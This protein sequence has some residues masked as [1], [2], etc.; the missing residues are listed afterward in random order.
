M[1]GIKEK[2]FPFEKEP[3]NMQSKPSLIRTQEK[4][5]N[6]KTKILDRLE[7]GKYL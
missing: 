6:Y 1:L 2:S 3:V 5:M 4:I 7:T